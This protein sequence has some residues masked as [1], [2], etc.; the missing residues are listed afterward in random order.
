MVLFRRL[1]VKKYLKKSCHF[2]LHQCRQ[3]GSVTRLHLKDLPL[4]KRTTE[5]IR[6]AVMAVMPS[7]SSTDHGTTCVK[8]GEKLFVPDWSEFVSERLVVNLWSCSRCGDRFETSACMSEDAEFKMSEKDWEQMF[9]A[10]LAA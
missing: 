1:S 7:M 8:C 4:S 2:D 3:I 9:P 6:E 5:Q 10:L